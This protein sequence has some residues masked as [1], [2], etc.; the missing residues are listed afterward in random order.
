MREPVRD[1]GRLEHMQK[2]IERVLNFTAEKSID[3][4][5]E[6]SIEYYGIVKC[7]EIVGEAAYKLTPLFKE[8]HPDTPWSVIEKMRHVLV[9]DYYQIEKSEVKYVVEDDLQPLHEQITRYLAGTNW[10]EWEKAK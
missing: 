6:N 5:S 1:K 10:E 7:I 2:A 8:A 3:D 4:L 9:H